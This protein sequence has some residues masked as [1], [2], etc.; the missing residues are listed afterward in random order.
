MAPLRAALPM[1]ILAAMAGIVP[2]GAPTPAVGEE[3]LLNGGFEV[4][5]ENGDPVGWR[6]SG[7]RLIQAEEVTPAEGDH[8]AQFVADG[9]TKGW[10][11][12]VGVSARAGGVYEFSG[13]FIWLDHS[14]IKE[15]RLEIRWRDADGEPL[16]EERSPPLTEHKAEWQRLS[17]GLR[18]A[19]PR[20]H[21]AHAVVLIESQ[22]AGGT[23]YL[24]DM[25]FEEVIPPPTATPTPSPSPTASATPTPTA[26]PAATAVPTPSHGLLI[27]GGFEAAADGV[28]V[29]WRKYGGTLEQVQSPAHSGSAAG[30]FTS[31][32][33]STKWVYQTVAVEGEDWYAFEGYV[34]MNDPNVAFSFLR[35]SWYAS[36]DGSGTALATCDSTSHLEGQEA[37]FRYLTT[38]SVQAPAEA[39]SAKARIMLEPASAASA[40]IFLDDTTF[41]AADPA[42]PTPIITSTPEPS[43]T[44]T[45]TAATARPTPSHGL[46]V[47]GGFEAAA[48]G[49][50]VGW[51]KHGGVLWQTDDPVRSGS[52]AGAFTSET[53]STKRVY[54]TVAVE[55]GAWYTFEGYVYANDLGVA[56]SFLRISW[57]LSG[58]GS[59]RVLSTRDS[60]ERLESPMPG[61]RYLTTGPVEAPPW[62]SSAKVGIVLVP[63]SAASATIFLDDMFFLP[64]SPATPTPASASGSPA[65]ASP[66]PRASTGRAGGAAEP[67]PEQRSRVEGA[68]R[69]PSPSEEASPFP[70]KINE[71]LYDPEPSG[72]DAAHEWVE[73]YNASPE[74]VNL[75]GWTLTDNASSDALTPVVLPSGGFAVV[76]A[77][78]RFGESWPDFKGP[79]LTVE[80]GRL[81]NGLSNQGDRLTLRDAEG[82]VADALSYGDDDSILDPAAPDV[83]AGHSLERAPA[84]RDSDTAGD[85]IDNGDPTPGF[86]LSVSRAAP[87][88][89]ATLVSE[90][91]SIAYVPQVSSGGASWWLW[92][93]V[94]GLA[95]GGVGAGAAY[96][97]YRQRPEAGERV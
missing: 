67:S 82:R 80:D 90:V 53:E 66:T 31:G 45:A 15:V 58:D 79:L 23:V 74:A 6:F 95:T 27:N 59:G 14:N 34:H 22:Q 69:P 72:D 51:Q 54:Q 44:E 78:E 56:A 46:L 87:S 8:A 81:G 17:M 5:E 36:P 70:V 7:E 64:A 91:S 40:T 57:Y 32:T 93:L 2:I 1:A 89:T 20:T 26:T 52:A 43:P 85:F 42:T 13:F 4:W 60:L 47:N 11:R 10:V 48:E 33:E 3:R 76:A 75:K 73:L 97:V 86:G 39:R 55:G 35:I 62:A 50:P 84:G 37:D 92:A 19:P 71:F 12:Q 88:A 63:A 61:F 49:V 83:G 18:E 21:S 96:L 94:G 38:G 24:D 28:P 25:S 41:G 77:S 29:G 68:V 16:L 30:S 65:A 9:T